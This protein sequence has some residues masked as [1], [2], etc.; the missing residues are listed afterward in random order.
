[1]ITIPSE[2]NKFYDEWIGW[3]DFLGNNNARK[4]VE[5]WLIEA[6]QLAKNNNDILPNVGW[7]YK[8]GY[9]GLT[10]VMWL[11]P[12]KFFH[13]KQNCLSTPIEKHIKL[14]EQLAKNNNGILPNYSWLK[15]N[16]YSSLASA[17]K[18]HRGKFTHIKQDYKGGKNLEEKILEA[19]QLAKQNN[20]V[21]P[22]VG[23]L[24]HNGYTGLAKTIKKYSEKFSHIKQ[25]KLK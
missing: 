5:E 19:E 7:L 15:D 16:G 24:N 14:A 23:W 18:E 12:K 4:T 6:E 9:S 10:R 13:I 20:G 11:Y 22:N 8:N 21:L 2:P 3:N 17:M 25:L 1:M